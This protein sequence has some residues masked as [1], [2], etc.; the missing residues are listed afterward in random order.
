MDWVCPCAYGLPIAFPI[1]GKAIFV[2]LEVDVA[3][4]LTD[5]RDENGID[6]AGKPM[7]L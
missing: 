6:F 1:Q 3:T 5:Q 7:I 2:R 4:D